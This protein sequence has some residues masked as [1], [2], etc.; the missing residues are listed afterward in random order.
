MTNRDEAR[1]AYEL[2]MAN[3]RVRKSKQRM[4]AAQ[5]DLDAATDEWM[6]EVRELERLELPQ[7]ATP[8]EPEKPR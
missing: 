2:E 5:R 3:Y 6:Q 4:D 1:H 7:P 8:A